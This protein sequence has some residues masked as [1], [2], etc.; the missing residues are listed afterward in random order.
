MKVLAVRAC[1][2]ASLPVCG[3]AGQAT[4]LG[5]QQCAGAMH[6][7]PR[8]VGVA[9]EGARGVGDQARQDQRL[10]A[11]QAGRGVR[12]RGSHVQLA[13]FLP[14]PAA[15]AVARFSFDF[16]SIGRAA[17]QRRVVEIS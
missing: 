11:G 16:A 8:G 9:I 10:V 17:P 1:Q 7:F 12:V 5:L 13:A 14:K 4:D 6:Q 15:T 2:G 3:G